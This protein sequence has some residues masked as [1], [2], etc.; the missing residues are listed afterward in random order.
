M[1]LAAP[2]ALL[3]AP[4]ITA[5][6]VTVGRNLQTHATV[7]LAQAAG[8]DGV[9]LTLTSDDPSRLLLSESDDKA[10]SA[11]ISLT[12][13]PGVVQSRAFWLQGLADSGTATYTVS[14]A[15]LGSAQG[16]VTLVPSGIMILGPSQVPKFNTTP[17][18]RASKIS[19]VSAALDSPPAEQPVAG[20]S[21][22]EVTITNSN[23]NAGKL[24]ASKLTL[25]GGS[26]SA[27]TY[28]VPAAEGE[29][30]LTPVQ[31]PGFTPA[32]K[33]ASVI[34]AVNKPGLAIVDSVYLGKDLQIWGAVILGEPAPP[35]GLKVTLTSS[36]ASKLL[37]STRADQLGTASITI[38]VAEG[39]QNGP[40]YLQGMGDSGDI[41]YDAAAPGFRT[42]TARIGLTKSGIIVAF[43]AYGPPDEAAVLMKKEITDDRRFYASVSDDKHP[44]A[45]R[46][47]S[48]YLDREKGRAADITVQ[49]LR[50]GVSATVVVRSSDPAVGTVESPLTIKPGSAV[51]NGH[52]TPLSVGT[53]IVSIDTPPGFTQPKNATSM[54]A[55]VRQ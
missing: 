3:A 50:A 49:G 36:D 11:T 27:L 48:A 44:M 5:P 6:A 17:R 1:A 14:A 46:V 20:G 32:A 21:Q 16:T 55:I 29:A 15:G 12:V 40:Y 28:F 31:P 22:V 34:A 18:G 19:V 8:P 53:T 45:I 43:G 38:T 10:G 39:S 13:R 37:L 52:F 24:Q 2:Y 41:Q 54:P 35:G 51:A 7:K 25:G 26:S 23:P 30:T 42:R 47:W 9:K 33:F 4:G